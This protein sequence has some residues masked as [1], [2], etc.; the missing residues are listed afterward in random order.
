MKNGAQIDC[1]KLQRRDYMFTAPFLSLMGTAESPLVCF[2]APAGFG[3]FRG[4]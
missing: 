2:V 4:I 3:L 1:Q